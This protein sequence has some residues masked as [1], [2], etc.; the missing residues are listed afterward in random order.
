MSIRHLI[1][2]LSASL[3]AYTTVPRTAAAQGIDVIRGQ[4]V[5][6]DNAPIAGVRITA[7][8]VSGGVNRNARTNEAGQFTIT[9]PGGE[10]D[11]FMT[12]AAIGFAPKQFELKRL[13]DEDFLVADATM[14]RAAASLDTVSVKERARVTIGEEKAPDASGT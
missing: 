8:S 1:I 9:F 5:G 3:L 12:Y 13:A 7:T 2:I 14:S 4:V 10:G 6:P 11:Y